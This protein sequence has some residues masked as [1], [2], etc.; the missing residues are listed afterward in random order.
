M[1]A[2][3]PEDS[4]V[5]LVNKPE[6]IM[7]LNRLEMDRRQRH[8]CLLAKMEQCEPRFVDTAVMREAGVVFHNVVV[9]REVNVTKAE[10]NA[11]LYHPADAAFRWVERRTGIDRRTLREATWRVGSGLVGYE[12]DDGTKREN[13]LWVC[14]R[15]AELDRDGSTE[16]LLRSL[17]RRHGEL[18]AQIG[19]PKPS[20]DTTG[21][22]E[23]APQ[24]RRHY[25]VHHQAQPSSGEPERQSALPSSAA[26]EE[27][28]IDPAVVDCLRLAIRQTPNGRKAKPH[29]IIAKARV[30]E[31]AGRNALRD[32]EAKG[33][34][35]GFGRPKPARYC[36]D[37]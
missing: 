27:T 4:D 34:Y 17:W 37:T 28:G 12:L 1:S 15:L 32:L 21:G 10:H 25:L 35:E 8:E 29:Q 16:E 11:V 5:C 36:S 6:L 2:K 31:Q 9:L 7:V 13:L 26:G 19:L 14:P 30:Q 22:G 18:A 3:N 20:D 24:K 23:S 33:E